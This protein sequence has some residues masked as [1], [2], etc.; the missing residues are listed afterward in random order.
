MALDNDLSNG[1]TLGQDEKVSAAQAFELL[2]AKDMMR[3]A[4][5]KFW[6]ALKERYGFWCVTDRMSIRKGWKLV[7]K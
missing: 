7:S 5:L 3:L 4:T 2:R 1:V 6:V